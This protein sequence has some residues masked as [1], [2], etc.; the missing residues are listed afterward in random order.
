[1][2]FMEGPSLSEKM[3]WELLYALR[4]GE[5]GRRYNGFASL[6]ELFYNVFLEQRLTIAVFDVEFEPGGTKD[7]TVKSSIGGT[8]ERPSGYSKEV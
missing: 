4:E 7:I 8:M 5:I 6:E 3:Y 1:M 2:D